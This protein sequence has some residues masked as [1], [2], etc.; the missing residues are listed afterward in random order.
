MDLSNFSA[1]LFQLSYFGF[2]TRRHVAPSKFSICHQDEKFAKFEYSWP[3]T[4]IR[5]WSQ[6]RWQ[7][8]T[9]NATPSC[10]ASC[11]SAFVVVAPTSSYPDTAR[12]AIA[13]A[14]YVC[15]SR[16]ATPYKE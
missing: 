9:R 14:K 12:I 1:A 3:R 11:R 4:V 8:P 15:W 6:P 7:Q 16:S 2:A 13:R 10:Y 5:P